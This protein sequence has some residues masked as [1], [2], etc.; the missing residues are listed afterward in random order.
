MRM[1]MRT[2]NARNMHRSERASLKN[3]ATYWFQLVPVFLRLA[4]ELDVMTTGIT[5]I[6]L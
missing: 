1:S 5:S 3:T 6:P 2:Q 4:Q